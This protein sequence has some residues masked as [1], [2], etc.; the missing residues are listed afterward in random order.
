M[1]VVSGATPNMPPS[2]DEPSRPEEQP[3]IEVEAAEA[4][5][6][7]ETPDRLRE[8]ARVLHEEAGDRARAAAELR[9]AAAALREE[10]AALLEHA[11]AQPPVEATVDALPAAADPATRRRWFG[12][13][14]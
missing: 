14:G 3:T 2:M 4:A 12:R 9:S 6:P 8:Q 5:L 13:R 7:G 1:L 11:D 10:A